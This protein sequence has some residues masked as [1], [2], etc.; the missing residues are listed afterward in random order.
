MPKI[1]GQENRRF[2]DFF[3]DQHRR[4]YIVNC[5]I[6]MGT[7]PTTDPID[8]VPRSWT[9]PIEPT[10]ARGMFVPPLDDHDIVRVLTRKERA[11]RGHH[12]LIDYTAWLQ[13]L[14]RLT[15]Q[16]RQRVAEIAQN[17]SGGVNTLQLLENPTPELQRYVGPPPFP[18]RQLVEAM[19]AGNPWALGLSADVPPKALAVLEK[20]KPIVLAQRVVIREDEIADPFSEGGILHAAPDHNPLDDVNE[21]DPFADLDGLDSEP[22]LAGAGTAA[23]PRGRRKTR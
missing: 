18:P 2:T 17:M 21:D 13:K 10:W 23:S 4:E 15:E 12:I 6:G 11:E 7:P 1:K 16:Y 14:D 22:A 19:A 8:M 5:E 20:I 9:A 3:F